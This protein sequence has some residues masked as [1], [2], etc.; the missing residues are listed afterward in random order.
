[1]ITNIDAGLLLPGSVG[2]W[3]WLDA[4]GNGLLDPFTEVPLN[5]LSDQATQVALVLFFDQPVNPSSA[6]VSASRLAWE[7][8]AAA[9]GAA[10]PEWT[11]L[12]ADVRLVANCTQT[13]AVV[14]VP[15][16]VDQ[17]EVIKVDTRSREYVSRVK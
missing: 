15:L 17:G 7:F 8:D 12:I 1:M 3:V 10:S 5:K 2:D 11:P 9:E 13:G 14:R 16:F 6:N 4:N